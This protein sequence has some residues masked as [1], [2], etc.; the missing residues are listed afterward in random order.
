[1]SSERIDALSRSLADST[2]RRNVLKLFGVG[3]AGTAVTVA[4]LN[5]ALAKNNKSNGNNGS[6]KGNG[7]KGQS[8][9]LGPF[10]QL[11]GIPLSEHEGGKNFKGTLNISQ[12]AEQGGGI[13]A[14][15][16]VTGKVTG[17]DVGNKTV[18]ENVVLPVQVTGEEVTTQVICQ[19]LNLVIGPIDLNLLGLRL[20][21][22]TIRIRL[23]ADSQGGILGS[24]LCSLT[25][26]IAGNPLAQIVSL[27]NQILGLLAG[28]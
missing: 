20:Q 4:G 24:L 23:T 3:V 14:I 27:L 16:T 10:E 25:G 12:F 5:E 9:D 18:N 19:V 11:T 7:N 2:S 22:D 8:N 1:M 13:V 26:P 15:G 6:G 17:K 21:V 28:L